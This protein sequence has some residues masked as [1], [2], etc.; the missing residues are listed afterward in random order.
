MSP[1]VCF[2]TLAMPV[3]PFTPRHTYQPP[4]TTHVT[5]PPLP[6]QA[7]SNVSRTSAALNFAAA[8]ATVNAVETALGDVNPTQLRSVADA[9]AAWQVSRE[10]LYAALDRA[11]A[12]SG[13]RP[14]PNPAG[15]Y[16][17]YAKSYCASDSSV[18]CTVDGD[19]TSG[20]CALAAGT[21]RCSAG[22][23]ATA[24]DVDADC[25]APAFCLADTGR[26]TSLR[27][28][29]LAVQAP[30]T[31]PDVAASA[32]ALTQLIADAGGANTA[33]AEA[34]LEAVRQSTVGLAPATYSAALATFSSALGALGTRAAAAN[35]SL[36]ALSDA[37]AA[38]PFSSLSG[39][40]DDLQ[41]AADQ[42]ES[43]AR[44]MLGN[45]LEVR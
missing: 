10:Q 25:T 14:A 27:S 42:L 28:L 38:I 26:V 31:P 29:L 16:T 17:L 5:C 9:L 32:A 24:C 44:P 30:G 40:V 8:S 21:R 36:D 35:A 4:T 2:P 37:I 15:D 1:R 19:C 23:Q 43:G 7:V 11:A 22:S 20:T 34:Q 33:G 18:Y 41:A 13:A 45:V 12:P 6:Q 3:H 39:K